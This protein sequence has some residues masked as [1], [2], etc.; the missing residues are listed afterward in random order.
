MP[1][2]VKD[3][4]P[5]RVLPYSCSPT[6]V[7]TH[8][9]ACYSV[10]SCSSM[11]SFSVYVC[12]SSF[13]ETSCVYLLYLVNLL[14]ES[15]QPAA[16]PSFHIH[17]V[18]SPSLPGGL[19]VCLRISRRWAYSEVTSSW[20]WCV[21]LCVHVEQFVPSL[22]SS[23]WPVVRV[24]ST[25]VRLLIYLLQESRLPAAEQSHRISSVKPRAGR[26][27]NTSS[28]CLSVT[29]VF[30]FLF[31][32]SHSI[33]EN[34]FFFSPYGFVSTELG[35]WPWKSSGVTSHCVWQFFLLFLWAVG[36]W[37]CI[38]GSELGLF[39]LFLKNQEQKVLYTLTRDAYHRVTTL[40]Q[41][42]QLK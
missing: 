25:C 31:S 5:P 22:S 27:T 19:Q 20:S 30:L 18:R 24:D 2:V 41:V 13:C 37:R 12:V 35:Q 33:R 7:C 39:S 21:W 4:C 3:E 9:N 26:E 42:S 6:F 17:S 16:A 23:I 1:Q 11:P 40:H 15:R 14:Q 32:Q 29:Q 34:C 10:F 38:N 28:R 8:V 36:D